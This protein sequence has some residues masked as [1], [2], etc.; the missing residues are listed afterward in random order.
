MGLELGGGE[1]AA[2]VLTFAITLV[3]LQGLGLMLGAIV[4]RAKSVGLLSTVLGWALLFFTGVLFSPD[5]Y[6]TALRHLAQ[7][8]PVTHGVQVMHDVT[9]GG[10]S[11]RSG[12]MDGDFASLVLCSGGNLFIGVVLFLWSEHIVRRRGILSHF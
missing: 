9:V 6:P 10:L 2:I 5:R 3:G 8:L 11:L 4:L 1:L 12:V 7:L